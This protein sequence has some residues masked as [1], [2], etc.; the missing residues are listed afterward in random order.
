MSPDQAI[1]RVLAMEPDKPGVARLC[2]ELLADVTGQAIV[3]EPAPPLMRLSGA[4]Q[5]ANRHA[6]RR[7]R[8]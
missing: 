4:M 2:Q 7:V 6:S 8:R 1:S 5:V 3:A